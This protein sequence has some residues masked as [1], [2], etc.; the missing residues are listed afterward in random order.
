MACDHFEGAWRGGHQP[1][2]EDYLNAVPEPGRPAL[3]RS[4]LLVEWECRRRDGETP[5][6][7]EYRQ[8]FPEHAELVQAVW[9]EDGELAVQR[10]GEAERIDTG[11]ERVSDGGSAHPA[12]LGRYPVTA[13][14]GAGN[15]GRVYL[16]HDDQLHRAVAIKVPH[17][18]LVSQPADV[19]AYLAEARVLASLDHPN[20]VP[21]H[22]VGTTE[23]GLP[24]M[25]SKFIE[26]SDLKAKVKEARLSFTESAGLVAAIAEVLHYAHRK[27][28]VHRDVKPGNILIDTGGKP[29][30]ADFG[31]ALREEDF[32][33][34]AAFAGTP[35]YMSPKQARGEGHR[36]DG[37]S[38]V[39]SLGVVFYELL[40]GRRP[41]Q[42]Q[43]EEL[44]EQVIRVEARPP[45]QTHDTIP[46]E[47]ER[48]C[49]KALAKRASER[50]TTAK[51]FAEDL[52]H[53]LEQPMGCSRSAVRTG[54][55]V[56]VSP[57]PGPA[58]TPAGDQ[59]P[60]EV[61]PKGLRSFDAGDTDFF[62]ELLPGPRDR[63]GLPDSIRFWKTRVEATD[64]D[65]TCSVGLL[66]GPSGCGKSS[67]VRAGLLPRLAG[68]VTPVYVEATADETEGRLLRGLRKGCPELPADLG[69]PE[70]LA[71]LRRGL[72]LP[73]GKK[74]LIV[75]D[76]FEQW[77][78]ARREGPD[79]ELVLALRQCDGQHVQCLVLVRDDFWLAVSRFLRDLEVPLAEGQNTALVDL[80]D[81]LHARKVLAEFGRAF[82]RLPDN[83]AEMAPDQERFLGQAVTGLAQGGKVVPVRLSLFAE[84]VKG[85]PW[86]PATWKGVGGTEGLGVQFLEETFYAPTAPPGHRLHQKA[87]RAVLKAL[88]PEHGTDI[89]GQMRS[90]EDL[91][92][93]SG[94][95]QRPQE[96]NALLRVLDAELRLVTPA[97]PEGAAGADGKP[98]PGRPGAAYY[99]L[100][101]DYL[102]PALRE[103]LTR[104]QRETRRGRAEL[105]LA[106]RAAAWNAGPQNRNLPTWWEWAGIRLYTR[107]RDWTP[108]QRR[109][110]RAAGRRYAWR[111]C[112]QLALVALA[113]WITLESI[114]YWWASALLQNLE[115]KEGDLQFFISDLYPH[116]RWAKPILKER[117][118]NGRGARERSL[119]C[120]ILLDLDPGES[121]CVCS[122][123]LRAGPEE[124][125]RSVYLLKTHR[126][127]LAA[128]LWDALDRPGGTKEERVRAA[129][130]LLLYDSES[131]RWN[132]GATDL[133][134]LL[135]QGDLDSFLGT[136]YLWDFR[137]GALVDPLGKI[138]RDPRRPRGEQGQAL[139]LLGKCAA[140]PPDLLAELILS[141]GRL[142]GRTDVDILWGRPADCRDRVVT[143]LEAELTR[144]PA[145]GA[146]A[147][148]RESLLRRKRHAVSALAALR[149]S[150][151]IRPDLLAELVA[152]GG[153][154]GLP[155]EGILSDKPLAYRD[156]VVSSLEE[157]LTRELP[158]GAGQGER[159]SWVR[160]RC[161]TVSTLVALHK[162]DRVQ[163]GLAAELALSGFLVS[164]GDFG[165]LLSERPREYGAQV[166]ALLEAEL[167][168][169]PPP[170]AGEEARESLAR[171]QVNA[172]RAFIALGKEERI[173]PLLQRGAAPGLRTELIHSGLLGS[174]GIKAVPDRLEKELDRLEKETD[175]FTRRALILHLGEHFPPDFRI[176]NTTGPFAELLPRLL[177]RYREDPDPGVHSALDWLLRR[178]ERGR[179]EVARV[180]QALASRRPAGDRRWYVNS[181]GH[182][183]AVVRGPV[184]FLMGSP[185]HEPGRGQD[186]TMHRKHI[187][188][189]YALATKEVTVRQFKNFLRDNPDIARNHPGIDQRNPEVAMSSV[190]WFEAVLYCRW[191]SE[192]EQVPE[193]QMCYPSIPE[194]KKAQ[195]GEGLKLP[196]GYLARAGYRLPTEAEWE[197]AC[198]A[199]TV[200]S[201]P[202][203][204]STARAASYAHCRR[205]MP[206][207]PVGF[208]MPPDDSGPA[209]VGSFKPNDLGLFDMLGNVSEWCQDR[210]LPYPRGPQEQVSEDR[211]DAARV[212]ART[213]RALR[214]GAFTSPPA[215]VR[216]AYRAGKPPRAR[217]PSIGFRVARTYR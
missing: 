64:P 212:T 70:A 56:A 83:L 204:A 198:R 127:A 87:A 38:D 144:R 96:F 11:P 94:Y 126:D 17:R 171:R 46:K 90:R 196:P 75:L 63:D 107:K 128:G 135:V 28:V 192:Q 139:E 152:A 179:D 211:E 8:R 117:I 81:A 2:I 183:L 150:D 45:R 136:G 77:L 191:L 131:P 120:R 154:W 110:M 168:R 42:G 173:W 145:P 39:F 5:A 65:Q 88:L 185:D 122:R 193:D 160:R 137:G 162:S 85:K 155:V 148:E 111:G 24:F 194:I 99:Q 112:V 164:G 214:G 141:H 121:A 167:A 14:L 159:E 170:E 37:R 59:R 58:V 146:V 95:A 184:E 216:S 7:Q 67:L 19:E 161:Y 40:T 143:L 97:D 186:E 51:D 124:Y 115:N 15:F 101:H 13:H 80:F 203:G 114:S 89:R 181:Q 138:A 103:W 119:A 48:I 72:S 35:A 10:L 123:L 86:T 74:V 200:T 55:P 60:V 182:T 31:L 189:S 36:V 113:V 69:L 23:D 176:D 34:G 130:A 208:L 22:D 163:P 217:E 47:L 50:Y 27:G 177:P 210:Y 78:H 100:T 142:G 79:T 68:H 206:G 73:P 18:H 91:L 213:P 151:G 175:D 172:A 3:L 153:H 134:S 54:V 178:G 25:V 125:Q 201:R 9:N 149:K 205:Y 116:R 169:K 197:Y 106:E 109:M 174:L 1:R 84:M 26:G 140:T 20:I 188:R 165:R 190:T 21:V 33:K 156:R 16:A 215:E 12:R 202:W 98:G 66:Y 187:P 129:Y 32:G 104:K 6:V 199:G 147:G 41:F 4:L 195:H 49:L 93:A 118:E 43:I 82:G 158:P 209:P 62:L 52:R 108:P 133:A 180:D 207:I 76:Q 53:F 30:V 132:E 44:L 57:T 105:R 71:G 29:Y 166:I 61:V 157:E 92:A 102:V